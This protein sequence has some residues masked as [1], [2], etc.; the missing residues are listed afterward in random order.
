MTSHRWVCS[1]KSRLPVCYA[2]WD[3]GERGA[4]Y[5][6][7]PEK[8]HAAHVCYKPYAVWS[9]QAEWTY[10]LPKGTQV[11]GI[12]AGGTPPS[13]SLRERTDVDIEGLGNVV[14]ATSDGELI[15]ITGSGIERACLSLSGDFVTMVAGPEWVFVVTRD[16]STTMDGQ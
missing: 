10:E 9:Q 3:E 16:G 4:L 5:A 11:L 6:C 8:E 14:V 12:A 15:F 1:F 13:K 7:Q 2:D